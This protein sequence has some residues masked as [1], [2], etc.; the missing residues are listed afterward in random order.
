V[1]R[2]GVCS[3]STKGLKVGFSRSSKIVVVDRRE[4]Q[5][6]DIVDLD[7]HGTAPVDT[8]DLDLWSRPEPVGDGDGSV[9]YSIAKIRAELH[10]RNSVVVGGIL[11]SDAAGVYPLTGLR[12][13]PGG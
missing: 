6:L 11:F 10:A 12:S 4:R 2:A 3:A 7:H 1:D 13:D 9:R 5:Q 8:S